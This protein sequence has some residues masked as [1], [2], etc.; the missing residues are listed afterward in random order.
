MGDSPRLGRHAPRCTPRAVTPGLHD[1]APT[2]VRVIACLINAMCAKGRYATAAGDVVRMR[3]NRAL[4]ATTGNALRGTGCARRMCRAAQTQQGQSTPDAG[5]SSI[6][7]CDPA[8]HPPRRP[9]RKC[10]TVPRAG[11]VHAR[12]PRHRRGRSAAT[13]MD[14]D[15]H[16]ARLEDAMVGGPHIA[17][18]LDTWAAPFALHTRRPHTATRDT[19][20]HG[21]N[22]PARD[23][24]ATPRPRHGG[25]SRHGWRT[26]HPTIVGLTGGT[27]RRP[28]D[29]ADVVTHAPP[30]GFPR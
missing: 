25:R 23:P 18:R 13:R 9:S 2:R 14:G 6:P 12:R 15:E 27:Q 19:A 11:A 21:V 4:E 26:G 20:N 16:G 17:H 29:R 7:V 1:E 28:T 10:P 22:D 30:V 5:A 3:L 24:G 8:E